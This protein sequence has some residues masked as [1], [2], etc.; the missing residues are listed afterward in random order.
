MTT[1]SGA[2]LIAPRPAPNGGFL[3]TFDPAQLVDAGGQL[4][5]YYGS[6]FG[7]IF[8]VPLRADGL[9]VAG[10][11]QTL[12]VRCGDRPGQLANLLRDV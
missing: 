11:Y 7:G 3:W 10:R 4:W 12:T 6:Y 2:P 9:A 5:L 8:T 1:D